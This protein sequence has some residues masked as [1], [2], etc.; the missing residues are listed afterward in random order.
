MSHAQL[1]QE[2]NQFLLIPELSNLALDYVAQYETLKSSPKFITVG[3]K[4]KNDTNMFY[5]A[6]RDI[7]PIAALSHEHNLKNLSLIISMFFQKKPQLKTVINAR[8]EE[9]REPDWDSITGMIR[10]FG[11]VDLDMELQEVLDGKEPM[12]QGETP[13]RY[14]KMDQLKAYW[15]KWIKNHPELSI[16]EVRKL[17]K[18]FDA[19][20]QDAQDLTQCLL[21][22]G[23]EPLL[24]FSGCK[25]YRVA[26]GDPTL[27][28]WCYYNETYNHAFQKQKAVH[29]Y[30]ALGMN[31]DFAQRLDISVYDN[32]KGVKPDVLAHPD[33]RL[34]SF[35]IPQLDQ[36]DT[37]KLCRMIPDLQLIKQVG[38]FWTSLANLCPMKIEHLRPDRPLSLQQEFYNDPPDFFCALPPRR[39]DDDKEPPPPLPQQQQQPERKTVINRPPRELNT[40]NS[41]SNSNQAQLPVEMCQGIARWLKQQRPN[42]EVDPFPYYQM[43]HKPRDNQPNR[44]WLR[45]P[46]WR[47]CAR[48]R[49]EHSQSS[50]V[51]FIVTDVD[52][53]QVCFS[54]RCPKVPIPVYAYEAYT[55]QKEKDRLVAREVVKRYHKRQ[56]EEARELEEIKRRKR[57]PSPDSKSN[58]IDTRYLPQPTTTQIETPPVETI[59]VPWYRFRYFETRMQCKQYYLDQFRLGDYR[60]KV[61]PVIIATEE[62]EANFVLAPIEK[63]A[64][65]EQDEKYNEDTVFVILYSEQQ[66]KSCTWGFLSRKEIKDPTKGHYLILRKKCFAGITLQTCVNIFTNTLEVPQ[67]LHLEYND[68]GKQVLHP[69]IDT[70]ERYPEHLFTVSGDMLF[71]ENK[72][73]QVSLMK[74]RILKNTEQTVLWLSDSGMRGFKRDYD[75]Y[76][77]VVD[78]CPVVENQRR[79]SIENIMMQTDQEQEQDEQMPADDS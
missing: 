15:S 47:W 9:K 79:E 10:Y 54:T 46:G 62:L 20:C 67:L 45:I 36:F 59:H 2:L 24:F 56:E 44:W 39:N 16:G 71:D 69:I 43:Q 65:L 76:L 49:T 61:Y 74:K 26:F 68:R 21:N 29:Y 58:S 53:H 5:H 72:P 66:K 73:E 40:S 64:W 18:P 38:Q 19:V 4:G 75:S 11:F 55:E 50:D 51:Y 77:P 17:C 37:H 25:G 7:K 30:T 23:K 70:A 42:F 78:I 14:E 22:H 13:Q 12:I 32:K 34:F 33:S 63:F 1:Q 41:N 52:C 8:G 28:Y 48:G 31:P 60:A 6:K 3:L 27:F 35:L 57:P